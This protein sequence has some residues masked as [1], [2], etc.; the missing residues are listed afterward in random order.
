M[1][2]RI[3]YK[4][5]AKE[6]LRCNI[7]TI[8]ICTLIIDLIYIVL[9][10]IPAIGPII[11]FIVY[12]GFMLSLSLIFL[13]LTENIKPQVVDIFKGFENLGNALWL[14][15]LVSFFALLWSLLFI[16]P[17]I[18]KGISYS[19][20][21]FIL[22]ENPKMSADEALNKSKQITKGHVGDLFVLYLSFFWWAML[23][24]ITFGLAAIYV[25]PYMQATLTNV[26]KDLKPDDSIVIS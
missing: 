2:D 16:V 4:S 17:G 15:I 7:G 8:I 19:M 24:A 26:Y 18:I 3:K 1:F 13:A 23:V 20:S 12:P 22:A 21:F 11:L 9:T 10:R 6:Q 5:L 14:N 25:G